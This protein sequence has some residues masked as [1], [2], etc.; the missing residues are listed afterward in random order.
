MRIE[1]S[2]HQI[3][4]TPALRDY[5]Q[6]KLERLTR[7]SDHLHDGHVILSVEKLQQK[8]EATFSLSGRSLHAESVAEDMYAAIDL[9]ADKLD[10][11]VLKHKEKLTDHHRGEATLRDGSFG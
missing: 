3:D 7:H 11:Q 4:V 2:G 8:A 5:V 10:R 1:I 9:L 6:S